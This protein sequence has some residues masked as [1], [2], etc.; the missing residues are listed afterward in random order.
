MARQGAEEIERSVE[1]AMTSSNFQLN[2]KELQ[3]M[4]ISEER[5]YQNRLIVWLL[6]FTWNTLIKH[7]HFGVQA[8]TSWTQFDR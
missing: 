4:H 5:R 1:L 6:L 8:S 3:I 7:W 2:L